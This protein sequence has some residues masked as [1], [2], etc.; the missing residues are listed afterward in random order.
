MENIINLVATMNLSE[1]KDLD[2][3]V[4]AELKV[5]KSI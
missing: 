2:K 1:L 3:A 5:R 4:K